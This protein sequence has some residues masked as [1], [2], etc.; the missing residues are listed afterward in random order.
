MESKVPTCT[1]N[2]KFVLMI[3]IMGGLIATC[4][5]LSNASAEKAKLDVGSDVSVKGE[6]GKSGVEGNASASANV[7]ASSSGSSGKSEAESHENYHASSEM[8]TQSHGNYKMSYEKMN[9]DSKNSFTVETEHHIYKPGEQV[10]IEGS[11]WSSLIATVGGIS[12]VSIQVTDNGGNVV[13][14]GKSQ[15]NSDG[16]YSA[17]FQLP[18]DA[19]NGAYTADAKGNVSADLL[20]TLSLKTQASLESSAKFVVVSPNAFAVKAGGKDFSV[21]VATNSSNVSD[22]K[23]DEQGK[24]LSFTV[25][26]ETGTK[27]VTEVTIPKSL[28]S[29]D[30]TVMID[31]QVMAQSDVIEK[32]DTNDEV[33]LELNYHHSTHQIDII[34]TNAVP[35]FSSLVSVVLV[36]SIMSI[37]ILSMKTRV[38]NLKRY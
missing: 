28:L 24:K 20:N 1:K 10:S 9:A 25:Q 7:S 34:G 18:S 4:V 17:Q 27:G 30:L 14:T 23:F 12:S 35:E 13:Y 33:T 26:G 21:Q 6:I 22:I 15:V 3:A 29:G 19:K 37:I 32:A 2:F 8:Q 31:G 36:F 5:T 16:D 11:I 38:F